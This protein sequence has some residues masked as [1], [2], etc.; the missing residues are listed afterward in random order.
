M[1]QRSRRRLLLDP[2]PLA[3]GQRGLPREPRQR[4]PRGV[5]A[6]L[7]LAAPEP[8]RCCAALR[9]RWP[10]PPAAVAGRAALQRRRGLGLTRCSGPGQGAGAERREPGKGGSGSG[11]RPGSGRRRPG[12]VAGA[13]EARLRPGA[14]LGPSGRPHCTRIRVVAA[15]IGG[16]RD[17]R[18]GSVRLPRQRPQA[19]AAF[20]GRGMPV[21]LCCAQMCIRPG[22]ARILYAYIRNHSP[23]P[24]PDLDYLRPQPRTRHLRPLFRLLPGSYQRLFSK[25]Q[26]WKL[27][28]SPPFTQR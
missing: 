28:S 20:V 18:E 17:W 26:S 5:P 22:V 1:A 2:V 15:W 25:E 21:C 3:A 10:R 19:G 27:C 4:F 6:R 9:P 12:S 23:H 8:E 16:M 7:G 11:E 24:S 14:A 13:G